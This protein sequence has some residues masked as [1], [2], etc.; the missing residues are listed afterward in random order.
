MT[1]Q[2]INNVQWLGNRG[3]TVQQHHSAAIEAVY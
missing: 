3:V 1:E 2:N